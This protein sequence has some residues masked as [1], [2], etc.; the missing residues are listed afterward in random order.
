MSPFQRPLKWNVG[1]DSQPQ[2]SL[3]LLLDGPLQL[4]PGRVQTA[5]RAWHPSLRQATF[6]ALPWEKETGAHLGLIA[7]DGHVVQLAGFDTPMPSA[8]LEQCVQPSHYDAGLKARARGHS[9]HLLLW[10]AG[11]EPS[12]FEQYVALAAVAGALGSL[13]AFLV[14]NAE[15]HSMVPLAP[16]Y[17]TAQDRLDMLRSMPLQLL[18]CG[19]V[20]LEVEG[21]PGVWMRTFGAHLLGLPDF[22]RLT[23]GHEE[24]QATFVMFERIWQYLRASKA[25]FE[26]GHTLQGGHGM[27]MR[28]RHAYVGEYFLRS[29]G[30]LFVLE[31]FSVAFA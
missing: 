3:Q 10:Y 14:L 5:L 4:Q 27:T 31:P 13:G 11:Q 7:W 17:A 20:K 30:E 26:V 29:P 8:A 19:L 6:T 2:L 9:T 24:G 22:A 25:R 1:D 12:R 28:L 15:A 21:T 23:R 16:L 18:F